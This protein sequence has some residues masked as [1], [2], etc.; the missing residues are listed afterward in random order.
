MNCDA[1][2]RF[3]MCS[4]IGQDAMIRKALE[5]GARDFIVKPFKEDEFRRIVENSLKA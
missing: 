5:L 1:Q 4:A 3:I 2:A